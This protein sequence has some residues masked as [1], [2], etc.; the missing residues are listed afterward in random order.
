MRRCSG[1]FYRGGVAAFALASVSCAPLSGPPAP[2]AKSAATSAVARPPAKNYELISFPDNLPSPDA[3]LMRTKSGDILGTTYGGACSQ[4]C[5]GS[6]FRLENGTIE[7]VH[8]FTGVPDGA[9]PQAGLAEGPNGVL[10][11][12]T[13]FGG[14]P[15]ARNQH[16]T[17]YELVPNASTYAERVVYR[18]KGGKDGNLPMSGVRVDTHGTLYGL[19]SGGGGSTACNY[20]CGTAYRLVV[21][22]NSFREEVLYRFRGAPDGASP[23]ANL[24]EDQS[25]ALYGVTYFGGLTDVGKC[26]IDGCGTIFKLAPSGPGY[27]EKVVHIFKGGRTDGAHPDTTLLPA[28]NGVFYGA[29]QNGGSRDNGTIFKLTC[30]KKACK[31]EPIHSFRGK[32]DGARPRDDAGLVPDGSGNLYGTATGGGLY[33]NG[34]TFV[35][36][37]S[38]GK[39]TTLHSFGYAPQDGLRPD[40]SL[41]LVHG[42]LLGTTYYGGSGG[43]HVSFYYGCGTLFVEKI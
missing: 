10:Y 36:S 12:T 31:E 21:S 17:V 18:F 16:G 37:P 41:L 38:T 24:V 22:R 19:T 29:T 23:L 28:G 39:E 27:T 8:R 43:C 33:G 26:A 9:N 20:G 42:D 5:V 6:V 32:G 30:T 4:N 14:G 34:T 40:A 25:G 15:E 11:G 1:I 7:T 35:F 2:A 3:A 13:Q